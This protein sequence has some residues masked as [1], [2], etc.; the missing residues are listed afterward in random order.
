MNLISE[1]IVNND[2]SETTTNKDDTNG[3][4]DEFE[5]FLSSHGSTPCL[6]VENIDNRSIRVI[7]EEFDNVPRHHHKSCVLKYWSENKIKKPKLL[8]LTQIVMAVP[9]PHVII[10]NL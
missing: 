7:T 8:Q 9:C 1:I 6:E 2:V 3:E 10:S 4:I 5:I